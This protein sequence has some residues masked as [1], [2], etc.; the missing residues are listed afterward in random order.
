MKATEKKDPYDKTSSKRAAE[1]LKRLA[2]SQ[3]KRLPVDLTA[4]HIEQISEL[5]A[6]G[7]AS[8]AAGAIR[9]AIEDAHARLPKPE[10]TE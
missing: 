6:A 5:I 8:T 1:H 2:A 9:R 4:L 10:K 3:G 7:F